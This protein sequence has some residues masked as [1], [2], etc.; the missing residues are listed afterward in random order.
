[1]TA[2][3]FTTGSVAATLLL[4]LLV[5]TL[6]GAPWH[7]WPAAKGTWQSLVFWS[8]FRTL[9]TATVTLA[10]I[11]EG[12]EALGLPVWARG[13]GGV[14]MVA[15][16]ALY[17]HACAALGRANT[18]CG[19]E[20]LVVGGP[21]RWAR[22]P[23]YASIIPAYAGM[24]VVADATEVYLLATALI[25]VYLCMALAE[26]PWL[27]AAYPG[28]YHVYA[29]AVPRFFNG[30]RARALPRLALR[31]MRRHTARAPHLRQ[32]ALYRRK[33]L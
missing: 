2:I 21:Y 13:A 16:L 31:R 20:G 15:S 3:A 9:N 28:A 29:H 7:I 33:R 23:Q 10:L 26:E 5:A 4:G 17:L 25:G 24:A 30:R 12:G 8:L 6:L 1:M 18:Y 14:V 22:N 32:A 11:E 19:R 27:R